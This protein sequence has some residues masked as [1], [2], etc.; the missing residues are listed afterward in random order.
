VALESPAF[1]ASD[2]ISVTLDFDHNFQESTLGGEIFV[3]VWAE[4]EYGLS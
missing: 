1:D 3:E 4:L 2:A